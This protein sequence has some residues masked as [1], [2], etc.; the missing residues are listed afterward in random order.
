MDA[1]RKDG[2]MARYTQSEAL[3]WRSCPNTFK[4]CIL[5]SRKLEVSDIDDMGGQVTKGRAA[6][7]LSRR[8][9]DYSRSEIT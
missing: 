1:F 2:G 7:C 5:R 3:W 6:C 9:R 8:S 4:G